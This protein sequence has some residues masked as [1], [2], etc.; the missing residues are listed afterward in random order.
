MGARM[1]DLGALGGALV[2]AV[3][4]S[5]C[6]AK[7][8]GNAAAA[9]T[10]GNGQVEEPLR[11]D[12]PLVDAAPLRR[13]T[14]EQYDNTVRDLLGIQGQPSQR[15]AQDE[16]VAA[17]YSNAVAPVSRLAVE[18]YG[19]VAEELALQAVSKLDQLVSCDRAALGDHACAS[20]FIDRFGARAYRRPLTDA[21]KLRYENLFNAHGSVFAD[22]IRL[23]VTGMLSSVHFV[24]HMELPGSPDQT[25]VTPL[26]SYQLASRLSYALWNTMPDGALFEAAQSGELGTPTGLRAQAERLL[27]DARARDTIASFHLQWLRLDS[28]ADIQKDSSLFPEWSAE[29]KSAMLRETIDFADYVVRRG[30]GK[31]ETL[32]TAP[33]SIVDGP[34]LALYGAQAAAAPGEPV[35]LNP[36]QRAGLLTQ[37]SFLAASAHAN[38][39]SPVQRGLAIRQNLL[40]TILPDPPANVNNNPPEP[41]PGAT[42]RERFAEHTAD[43]SCARCHELIDPIGFGFEQYD[44][45]GRFRG[46]DNGLPI[47]TR[48][49]LVKAGD[50]SGTFNGAVELSRK[51][52]HSEV[53]R[54]CMT[55]QWF[56]FAL[57]RLETRADACSMKRLRDDFSASGYDVKELLLSIVTSDAFR[58]YRGAAP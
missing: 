34:L 46:Q 44:A 23:I 13:L 5:A 14:R 50:A 12:E 54:D 41:A 21:E 20:A 26:A 17:F 37:A 58:F 53:V 15:I 42:T 32:L 6:E 36:E 56:R 52:A 45:I 7:I 55:R 39:T 47:D 48:G 1:R 28:I 24:Y 11:C 33:F 57:G 49:E 18:Q 19:G 29:L 10:G 2:C 31:L 4:C 16:K 3:L 51:L 30:D 27:E 38:Q 35:S 43:V 40:C 8:D 25:A 22:G 9:G